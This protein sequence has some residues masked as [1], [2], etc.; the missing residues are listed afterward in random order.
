ML[1]GSFGVCPRAWRTLDWRRWYRGLIPILRIQ[2]DRWPTDRNAQAE[3]YLSYFETT[4]MSS[5][6]IR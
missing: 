6:I 5:V 1:F 4:C 2:C 3:G